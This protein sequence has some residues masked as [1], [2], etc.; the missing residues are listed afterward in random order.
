VDG[1]WIGPVSLPEWG[2]AY[3]DTRLEG[4]TYSL[5]VDPTTGIVYFVCVPEVN[6][7]SRRLDVLRFFQGQY[8]DT[9][10]LI[11]DTDNNILLL[12]HPSASFDKSGNLIVFVKANSDYVEVWGVIFRDGTVLDIAT[13]WVDPTWAYADPFNLVSTGFKDWGILLGFG[14]SWDDSLGWYWKLVTYEEGILNYTPPTPASAFSGWA[15]GLYTWYEDGAKE[16]ACN[17]E[18]VW[19]YAFSYAEW[20]GDTEEKWLKLW[21]SEDKVTWAE[22]PEWTLELGTLFGWYEQASVAISE[23]GLEQFDVIREQ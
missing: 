9:R 21:L 22:D 18:G 6:W 14:C 2:G 11:P 7:A 12:D 20:V 10:E 17:E 1:V 16:I 15:G 13:V 5:T 23:G 19:L 3:G 8:L 4:G